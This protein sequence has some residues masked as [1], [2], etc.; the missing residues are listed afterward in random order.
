MY[1]MV[2]DRNANFKSVWK[3]YEIQIAKKYITETY[4]ISF[5]PNHS[6]RTQKEKKYNK[7]I[8]ERLTKL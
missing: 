6:S 3:M 5:K 8:F 7:V 4:N 1:D 2:L